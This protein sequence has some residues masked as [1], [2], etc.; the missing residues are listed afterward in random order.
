MNEL[1]SYNR[2]DNLII[3]GLPTASAA[4]IVSAQTPDRGEH[5]EATEKAV[6]EL[7]RTQLHVPITPADISI[8]HRLRKM[9][10]I[11]GPPAVIVRFT[12]RK[13]RDAVYAARYQLRACNPPTYINEDLT[14]SAATLFSHARKLVKARQIHKAWTSGGNVYYRQNSQPGC[15]PVLLTSTMDLPLKA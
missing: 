7:F 1:E 3:T 15:K 14:K 9:P 5:T 12:N 13:A 4:E 8:T 10:K 2:R 6:Q 11:S